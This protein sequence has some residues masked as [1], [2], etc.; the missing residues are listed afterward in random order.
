[1]D[2][3]GVP[4]G[5]GAD[6]RDAMHS[7]ARSSGPSR[8]VLLLLLVA[9]VA[10]TALPGSPL[11]LLSLLGTSN[12]ASTGTWPGSAEPV[13]NGSMTASVATDVTGNAG[14]DVSAAPATSVPDGEVT[15]GRWGAAPDRPGGLGLLLEEFRGGWRVE[16]GSEE[17]AALAVVAAH[18]WADARRRPTQASPS[19]TDERAMGAIV[20]IEAVE[21]PG[22]NHA[23]V[24]TLVAPDGAIGTLHRLAIPVVM[25][26]LGPVLAGRPWELPAPL[27]QDAPLAGTPVD[28]PELVASA[29]RALDAVGLP[30]DRLVALDA[31]DGWPFI[32]RFDDEALAHPWLRWHLDRFV[33]SGLPLSRTGSAPP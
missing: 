23:V 3:G 11:R 22:A 25:G 32:A 4:S 29:R 6:A 13:P 30:G 19:I 20:V 15:E 14:T 12:G 18:A 28:D 1:M 9:V 7:T 26:S 2:R 10:V 16:G 5:F 27:L 17:A 33:V 24:T 8:R 31:T 21:R